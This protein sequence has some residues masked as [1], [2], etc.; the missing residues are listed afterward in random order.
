MTVDLDAVPL[1]S[2]VDFGTAPRSLHI[3]TARPAR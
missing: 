1:D 3:R 2:A